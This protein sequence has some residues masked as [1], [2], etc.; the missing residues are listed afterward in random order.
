MPNLRWL[1]LLVMLAYLSAMVAVGI[2]FSRRQTNTETYFV[3]RRSIPSWAMGLSLLATLITSVT[4][5]AY[6]GA[7]YGENWS[8]LV[9]GLMV[10][11]V[12]ALVGTVVVP[13]YRREVGM[14]AYEYFGKRFGRPTRMY[15]S[16]AFS[17]THFSKMGF[18]FYLL[19]LTIH[20]MTGWN[21]DLVILVA[22]AATLVYTLIGGLEAVIWT[23]VVQGFVLWAGIV[24]SLAFLL[25]L[26]PGGPGAVI[27]LA[28]E[29]HKFSLGSLRPDFSRA[30]VPV[31]AIYGFFWYLQRY[32]ADQTVVQRYL[33]A[34][35]DR[36]AL[37]GVALGA[38]LCVPVWTLFMLIGSCTWSFYRL[39]GERLPAFITKPDQVFPYFLSTHLPAGVAGLFMAPLMGAAM[40]ALAS[41][42]NCLGVVG[43]EDFYRAFR[44]QSSDRTRLRVGKA[45]IAVCGILCMCLAVVL[46]HSRGGALSMW[47]SASAIVAGGLAGLFLLAFLSKRANRQ[48][49]YAGIAACI[50]FTGWATLT[51][52]QKKIVDL[53]RFNFPWSDLMIGAVG[54]VMLVVV[55]YSA[56]LLFSRR[57]PGEAG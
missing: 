49:I 47:F 17:L 9:P 31:L 39:T 26:P 18:V 48:G 42:L 19:A 8:L 15:A 28:W 14:S 53:G 32:T 4:F 30:T 46:A 44:P 43:V 6:P 41:D 21:T 34:K 7:A 51:V 54:H 38:L 12:L 10:I 56:S 29:N 13:F 57:Q 33:V 50:L 1:D 24:V 2:H 40:A 37:K 45:I 11:V 25:F 20:S 27:S 5:I 23:D 22:G 16:L 52:G 3:A 36:G 35:S 55:G